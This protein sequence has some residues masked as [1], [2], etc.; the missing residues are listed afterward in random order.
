MGVPITW[1]NIDAP[2]LRGVSS[3]LSGAHSALNTGF[4]KLGEVI[5]QRQD[6]DAANW[7]QQKTNNTQAFLDEIGKYRT[8]EE[9]QAALSSG[10]LDQAR[11]GYGAQ[12]DVVAA[13][14]AEEGRLPI[15]QNRATTDVA[16]KNTMLDEKQ[17]ADRDR[18]AVLNAQGKTKEAL[19]LAQE[20]GLRQIAPVV[21]AGNAEERLRTELGYKDNAELRAQADQ[22]IQD[23]AAPLNRALVQSQINHNNAITAAQNAKAAT[24]GKGGSTENTAALDALVK[25]S[26]MSAGTLD[27]KEGMAAV[28]DW[29]NKNVKGDAQKA[30]LLYNIGRRASEGIVI[31]KDDKGNPIKAPI[32]AMT[33][34]NA[35]M[36]STENPAAMLVP[37]WSRRGDDA[38][39]N[40]LQMMKNPELLKEIASVS[41]A[42]GNSMYPG[43]VAA[44]AKAEKAAAKSTILG[45]SAVPPSDMANRLKLGDLV[46]KKAKE[47]Q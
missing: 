5:K 9:Y 42:Q 20:I 8:P 12:L 19:A 46:A 34:I 41:A 28:T 2:D 39:N 18:V 43:L 22:K 27:T 36:G 17:A 32:P 21:T 25:N 33:M 15:L 10:V 13:R 11:Q 37:G 35:I 44:A 24:E 1:R 29:V 40:L 23:A 38:D 30:D 4:D 26:V 47:R 6:V 31:G 16:Y 3:I 45:A 14:A 7:N